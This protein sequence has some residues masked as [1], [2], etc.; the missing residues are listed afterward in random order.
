V[1]SQG[2][3]A[4]SAVQQAP[5]ASGRLALAV[6]GSVCG[7]LI[8][9]ALNTSPTVTLIGAALGSAVPALVT[10]AGP[11][12]ALRTGV[13]IAVTGVALFI[14]YGGF[15]LFDYATDRAETFPAPPGVA[16]P[17]PAEPDPV[18]PDPVPPDPV[19]PDPVPPDPVPPDPVP[20]DPVPPDPVP[21]PKPVPRPTPPPLS[22]P[23]P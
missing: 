7:A 17:A 16:P 9:G 3:A 8:T 19:P 4:Q 2:Y 11:A 20:P 14:T 13:A 12:Q 5:S 23:S 21:Q 10:F 22:D 6:V 1:V 15:T 18:P